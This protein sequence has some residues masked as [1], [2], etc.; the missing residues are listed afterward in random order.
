VYVAE[1]VP[2][3]LAYGTYST[4]EEAL[5]CIKE[6]ILEKQEAE[7]KIAEATE[8]FDVVVEN[9]SLEKRYKDVNPE[10]K[11]KKVKTM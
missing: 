5:D 8:K 3:G 1:Y 7:K 11:V 10:K 2:T 9:N 6:K 4:V